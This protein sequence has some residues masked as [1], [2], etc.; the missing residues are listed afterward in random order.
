MPRT[1]GTRGKKMATT[2][3]STSKTPD[4]QLSATNTSTTRTR[5]WK[6]HPPREGTAW[7]NSQPTKRSNTTA[8]SARAKRRCLRGQSHDV[9][10]TSEED[11]GEVFDDAPL[12]QADIPKIVEV[13]MNQLTMEGDEFLNESQE[14]PHL[15]KYI[16]LLCAQCPLRAT[17][18]KQ[19]GGR[20]K[21]I[22]IVLTLPQAWVRHNSATVVPT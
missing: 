1:K 2:R 19:K 8:H 5:G 6:N 20:A 14:N 17:I 7:A 21:I 11:T 22:I 12:T 15:G 10:S 16:L 13:V 18:K 9:S 3:T 4:R